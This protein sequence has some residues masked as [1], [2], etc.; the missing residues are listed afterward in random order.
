MAI[1]D[2]IKYNGS[3]DIFAWKYPNEE[4]STWTQLVVSESQEAI[5]FKGGKALDTFESGTYTL[6][7]KNIPILNEIINLP[8]GG[9]SPFT[10]EVWYVNKVNSLD[11]KWGTATPIQLQDP[12]YSIFIPVRAFGQF[13]MRIEDTKQFL[14]K[15]VGT[16]SIFDK[17]N[18]TQY[19]RGLYLTKVKDGNFFISYT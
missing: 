19:F 8:F 14:I 6:D 7:T 13:G 9:K 11:I 5:L 1:V 10:A 4:L 15:L 3:P 12:K 16:L 18:V 2:V 17:E